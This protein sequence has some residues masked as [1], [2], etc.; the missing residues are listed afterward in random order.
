MAAGKQRLHIVVAAQRRHDETILG[1]VL[2]RIGLR[3]R[4]RVIPRQQRQHGIVRQRYPVVGHILLIA[5]KTD[6]RHPLIQPLGHL[7]PD[8]LHQLDLH[9]RVIPLKFPYH[10]RQPVGGDTGIGRDADA[11]DQQPVHLR[12]KL[13]NAVLLTQELPYHR[14]QQLSVGRQRHALRVAAEQRKPHLLLQRRYQLVH[15]GGR[16]PQRLRRPG[17]APRLRRCQ[18]GP[19]PCRFHTR[20]LQD[21]LL[22]P[23]TSIITKYSFTF[24]V[25]YST[26]QTTRAQAPRTKKIQPYHIQ[27][28]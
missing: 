6:V 27:L 18:K 16:I 24:L 21:F 1:A 5:Q 28:F 10:R 3:L 9:V 12:R 19:A 2:Q 17:K 4:Q 22:V 14:Q 20:H 13:E 15:A 7:L 8:A 25:I 11:A 26:I 23:L